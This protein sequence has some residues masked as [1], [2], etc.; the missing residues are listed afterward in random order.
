MSSHRVELL[1][2]VA[3]VVASAAT[4]AA[5]GNRVSTIAGAAVLGGALG[6]ARRQPRAAWI[7]GAAAVLAMATH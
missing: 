3:A 2:G 7:A 5:L 4:T 6:A 1:V